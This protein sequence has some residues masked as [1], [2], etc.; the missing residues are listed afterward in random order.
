MADGRKNNG[1]HSTKGRAGRKPKADEI[2]KIEMMDSIGDPKEAWQALW[3]LVKDQDKYAIK[4]WL[5]HRYGKPRESQEVTVVGD[6]PVF[7][8]DLSGI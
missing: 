6:K 1:G 7:N 4:T 8:V 3:E 2:K 5:E